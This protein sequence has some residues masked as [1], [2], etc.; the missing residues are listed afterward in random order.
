MFLCFEE[1]AVRKATH[2]R[3]AG[4]PMDERE[5]QRVFCEC[6]NCGFGRAC[7]TLAKLG[8][9]VGIPCPG[10]QQIFIGVWYPY[11]GK[12]HGFLNR[13]AFT[14]SQGRTAEGFCSSRASR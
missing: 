2:S 9:N 14:C 10:F 11:D 8:A 6:F 1:Y 7:E 3:A 5:L 12:R 4:V 13:P